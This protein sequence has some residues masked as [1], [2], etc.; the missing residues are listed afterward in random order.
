MKPGLTLPL[1][2][3]QTA[4]AAL[5]QMEY[6]SPEMVRQALNAPVTMLHVWKRKYWCWEISNINHL[7]L[8]E[9]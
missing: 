3:M 8:F 2:G 4:L 6:P 5:V 9:E 7:H 1:A